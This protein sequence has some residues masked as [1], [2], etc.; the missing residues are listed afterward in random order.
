MIYILYFALFYLIGTSAVLLRNLLE[1]KALKDVPNKKASSTPLVSICIPARNEEEVIERCITSVL[2]QNYTQFEVLVLD[3]NSTDKTS[4]I[5][6]ELAGIVANLTH[7]KGASKPI[8][9]LGKPWACH[10]LSEVANGEILV[11]IDADVWLEPDVISNTVSVLEAK[12]AITVWPQQKMEGFWENMIIPLVYFALYT[13]LPAKYVERPPRWMPKSLQRVF[14]SK[15]VAA[16]G[17][18]FAFTSSA[19]RKIDGHHSVK[20]QVV[21]DIVLAKNIKSNGLSLQMLHGVDSVFCRMYTSHSEIWSGFKKNFLAGFGNLFEFI[22]MG[23]LHFLVF[24][25]PIYSLL[26]GILKSDLFLV[27]LSVG[28]ITLIFIQ[29]FIL[30]YLFK[31]NFGYVF[32]HP[33]SVLWFQILAIISVFNKLFGIKTSW[34]GREV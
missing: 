34:K 13:L 19:Y 22:F 23:V 12:D 33:L 14:N 24:L 17:Q 5:L 2:K 8:D 28:V 7:I 9:W 16:C 18:F 6:S 21:E 10:Q 3:D 15:F 32:L 27:S 11:F 20:T 25:V 1:L 30:S 26:I 31:W 4:E 29:R